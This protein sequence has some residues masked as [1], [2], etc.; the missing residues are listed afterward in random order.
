MG[1]AIATSPVRVHPPT[2]SLLPAAA[3]PMEDGALSGSQL[4]GVSAT[5]SAMLASSPLLLTELDPKFQTA[6][7]IFVV[8]NSINGFVDS[9]LETDGG[10]AFLNALALMTLLRFGMY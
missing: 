3:K 7:W 1:R 4:M 5:S 9:V 6:E 10:P 2:L 8:S